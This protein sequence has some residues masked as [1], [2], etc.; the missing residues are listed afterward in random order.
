MGV[1]V[2]KIISGAG[3]DV[4]SGTLL[5]TVPTNSAYYQ[6]DVAI[7][8][9]VATGGL[10]ARATM[11]LGSQVILEN[12]LIPVTEVILDDTDVLG[13]NTPRA[14][15]LLASF[16]AP[17]GQKLTINTTAGAGNLQNIYVA[18]REYGGAGIPG[19]GHIDALTVA[20][21][22][23]LNRQDI[24]QGT[25]VANVPVSAGIYEVEVYACMVN[26]GSATG[27]ETDLTEGASLTMLV[28]S[29]II[30]E[31]FRL[32]FKSARHEFPHEESDLLI[33]TLATAGS[34]LTLNVHS[35]AMVNDYYLRYYVF[36]EPVQ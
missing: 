3:S 32:P 21:A 1:F 26:V 16:I 23:E 20:V 25:P 12:S 28:D 7:G 30:A 4:L 9:M 13:F 11:L 29:D 24:L 14:D 15:R 35:D 10:T 22:T 27:P 33:S 6:V 5:N 18:A 36:C 31:N 19:A 8:T 2:S 34:K 17:A